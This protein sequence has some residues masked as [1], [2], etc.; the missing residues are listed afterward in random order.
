[1]ARLKG[2]YGTDEFDPQYDANPFPWSVTSE[3]L[4]AQLAEGQTYH[5]HVVPGGD[6]WRDVQEY[7]AKRDGLSSAGYSSASPS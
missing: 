4:R 7:I 6:W 5:E 2:G 3:T 1:M